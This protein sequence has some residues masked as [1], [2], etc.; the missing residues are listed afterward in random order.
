MK[1]K[2]YIEPKMEVV[3]MSVNHCIAD[4][5]AETGNG[6]LG[7]GGA[8]INGII[9]PEGNIRNDWETFWDDRE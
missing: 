1:N 4:V 7:Y 2:S 3:A 5:T 8:D 9:D 6:D